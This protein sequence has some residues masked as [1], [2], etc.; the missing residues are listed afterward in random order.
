MLNNTAFLV[1]SGPCG[2]R[3]A[4]IADVQDSA[5]T[6]SSQHS[7]YLF[8]YS[9]LNHH[10]RAWFT[11]NRNNEYLQA[12]L[13]VVR[14]VE[15][16]ATRG[17]YGGTYWVTSYKFTYSVTGS[18]YTFV[19]KNDNSQRIF[20]GNSD[21]NSVVENVFDDAFDARY[22]RIYP[23]TWRSNPVIRWEVYGCE[24]CK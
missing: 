13:G 11:T 18:S 6:G 15:K 3:F 16:V 12:D 7:A 19:L 10:Y 24:T 2:G 8:S 21:A 9:R 14:R 20:A 23:M 1:G 22:V 4:Y 5:L 17:N